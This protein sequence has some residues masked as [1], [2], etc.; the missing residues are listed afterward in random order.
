MFLAKNQALAAGTT[1][2][3]VL[4]CV[5][6]FLTFLQNMPRFGFLLV[7][8]CAGQPRATPL[9][10]RRHRGRMAWNKQAL[11]ERTSDDPPSKTQGVAYLV[12]DDKV[13]EVLAGLDFR[14]KGGYTRAVVDVFPAGGEQRSFEDTGEGC[15]LVETVRVVVQNHHPRNPYIAGRGTPRR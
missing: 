5:F 1:P 8:S 12:P 13:E 11:G 9:T 14:E 6:L 4:C 15:L 2:Q 10:S 3:A 7:D